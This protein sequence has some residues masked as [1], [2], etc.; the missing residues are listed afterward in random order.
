M[1]SILKLRVI[2]PIKNTSSKLCANNFK[3]F[4]IFTV[5]QAKTV[6]YTNH[7]ETMCKL[8]A[9]NWWNKFEQKQNCLRQTEEKRTSLFCC[10]SSKKTKNKALTR[11]VCKMC[12]ESY[13]CLKNIRLTSGKHILNHIHNS[14]SHL[15]NLLLNNS[16]C[17]RK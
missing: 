10:T 15:E 9:N 2:E 8:K 1:V 7:S 17:Y 5:Q 16:S 4:Y 14:Y 11:T 13:L 3:L 6:Y 12:F